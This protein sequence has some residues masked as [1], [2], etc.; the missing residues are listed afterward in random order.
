MKE[1][2]GGAMVAG[3]FAGA[4]GCWYGVAIL[5]VISCL[6]ML[7]SCKAEQLEKERAA[8]WRKNYPSYKY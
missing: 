3:L 5:A 8:S 2:S 6:A 4:L 7:A 1:I